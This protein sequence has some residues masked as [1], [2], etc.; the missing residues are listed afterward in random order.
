MYKAFQIYICKL[1][2]AVAGRRAK[3]CAERIILTLRASF[4]FTMIFPFYNNHILFQFRIFFTFFL[5]F[6]DYLKYKRVEW[7][8]H[9]QKKLVFD[10]ITVWC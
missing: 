7:S 3:V 9:G 6:L 2:V 10:V 1:R 8:L 5:F 4:R